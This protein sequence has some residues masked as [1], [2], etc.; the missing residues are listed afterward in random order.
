MLT[1]GLSAEGEP[2]WGLFELFW[3]LAWNI[4]RWRSRQ[5]PGG[6]THSNPGLTANILPGKHSLSATILPSKYYL[7]MSNILWQQQ[8][9]QAA[10]TSALVQL[11]VNR[12]LSSC[13][14]VATLAVVKPAHRWRWQGCRLEW[15]ALGCQ[16][17]PG[18]SLFIAQPL[19]GTFCLN[20]SI[21][22][23]N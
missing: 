22:Q 4:F 6:E 9:C 1:P 14:H 18:C 17:W 21:K 12:Q 2:I 23:T 13:H 15:G 8:F 10:S 11:D 3:K 16:S 5:V 19:A 20:E 7:M